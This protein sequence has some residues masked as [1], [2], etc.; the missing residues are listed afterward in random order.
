MKRKNTL[1]YNHVIFTAISSGAL[2][3]L[4]YFVFNSF[5]RKSESNVFLNFQFTSKEYYKVVINDSLIIDS[6][7]IENLDYKN[8]HYETKGIDFALKKGNYKIQIKD[9]FEKILSETLFKIENS[10][11][12][13]IYLRKEIVITDK[14]FILI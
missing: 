5:H 13:Y 6:N 11:P 9:S 3:L 4:F 8:E 7:Q 10:K 12:K 2:I 14:P 1:K